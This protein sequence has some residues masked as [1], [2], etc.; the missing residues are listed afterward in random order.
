MTERALSEEAMLSSLRDIRLPVDASGGLVADMAVAVG[1]ASL[2]ALGLAALFR[3]ISLQSVSR[4]G[5][6]GRAELADLDN[7]PEPEL[8]VALLHRLR[9]LA[10]ERYEHLKGAIYE[11]GGGIDIT[12][13][14]DEVQR[15]V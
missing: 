8:R 3:L 12:T 9:S 2:V 5:R 13:L 1:L 10:P 14:Q 11:P 7:L 15:H 6:I 4:A